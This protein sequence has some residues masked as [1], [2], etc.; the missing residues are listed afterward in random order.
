MTPDIYELIF[1]VAPAITQV[2]QMGYL[3][4]EDEFY[5]LT[6]EQ[7]EKCCAQIGQTE[8]RLF[9]LLP[10]NPAF[11][12]NSREIS[13][14]TERQISWFKRAGEIIEGYCRDSG[15]T[16]KNFEEK[17]AYCA[18]VMPKEFS[19]GSKTRRNLLHEV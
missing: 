19:D 13:V 9:M 15:K 1:E 16:F 14:V 18:T 4:S 7:H 5:E 2:F 6:P 10:K 8:E 17:L 12:T 3:P 11:Q